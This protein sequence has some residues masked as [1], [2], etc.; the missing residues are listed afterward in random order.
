MK[1]ILRQR[2]KIVK[3]RLNS[4]LLK[5]SMQSQFFFTKVHAMQKYELI[6]LL[7]Y[8]NYVPNTAKYLGFDIYNNSTEFCKI[9]DFIARVFVLQSLLY[10]FLQKL[11]GVK[12]RI[13]QNTVEWLF[14]YMYIQDRR[15]LSVIS[16]LSAIEHFNIV[17]V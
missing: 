9:R 5:F 1:R 16:M 6:V 10:R 15:F 13:S 8:R 12:S 4:P 7:Y 14:Y 11:S 17:H 2:D 3:F